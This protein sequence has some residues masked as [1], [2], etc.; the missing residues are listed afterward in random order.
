MPTVATMDAKKK[1]VSELVTWIKDSEIGIFADYS[2]VSVSEDT[3]FRKSM[4]ELGI[5]Y[6]IVKNTLMRFAIKDLGIK[7]FDLNTI[8]GPTAL[9]T[10]KNDILNICK[11]LVEFCKKVETFKIKSGFLNGENLSV[12]KIELYASIPS[13]EIMVSKIMGSLLA[14]IGSLVRALDAISKKDN[15]AVLKSD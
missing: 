15:E 10:S 7:D 3:E 4:R 6:K 8:E 13:K 2:G 12:E 9:A 1:I 11:I 14:P 5:K